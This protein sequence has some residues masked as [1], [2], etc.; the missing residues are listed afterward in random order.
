MSASV[1]PNHLRKYSL[2]QC[3]KEFALAADLKLS[4][5]LFQV[6]GLKLL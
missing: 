4:G 3:L 1:T 5:K 6:L 2:I